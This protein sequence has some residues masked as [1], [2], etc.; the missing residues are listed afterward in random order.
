[1]HGG[2]PPSRPAT[3]RPAIVD[4]I[5]GALALA[6]PERACAAAQG[7]MNNLALGARGAGAWDYYETLAGGM[8]A[9]ARGPGLSAVQVHMTNTRNT[10]AEVLEL[11]LPLRVR[12]HAI[13]RG[14]GGG[15]RHRGGDGMVRELEFLA[16]ATATLIGERRRIAPWGLAGGG[17]GRRGA[18]SLDGIPLPGKCSVEVGTGSR[19]RIET[20]GGGGWGR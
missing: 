11:E 20:P 18:D 7:T 3:S 8:G 14:S 5:L 9:H 10:P 19:L 16:P 6:L 2:R 12:T 1:M 4:A 13:R 17:P 15:G